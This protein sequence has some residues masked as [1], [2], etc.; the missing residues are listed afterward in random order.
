M[1][2]WSRGRLT[3]VRSPPSGGSTERSPMQSAPRPSTL[4][5]VETADASPARPAGRERLRRRLLIAAAALVLIAGAAYGAR[6]FTVG[7][8]LETTDNAYL[9]ADNAVV[10]PKVSGYVAM[11][12]VGDNQVVAAGQ[13]LARI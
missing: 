3:D 1:L 4:Q 5:P 8:F 13:V 7:R 6:W 12:E 10:A 11:V 2:P 9:Q